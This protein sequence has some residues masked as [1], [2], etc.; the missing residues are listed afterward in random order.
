M[1]CNLQPQWSR[2][3]T[4]NQ[5][6]LQE[7]WNLY[8]PAGTVLGHQDRVLVDDLELEAVG[9]GRAVSD[10]AR[11]PHHVEAVVRRTL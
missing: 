5:D 4:V 6:Q 9:G 2:E 1:A 3:D 7:S 8:L 10:F 11:R